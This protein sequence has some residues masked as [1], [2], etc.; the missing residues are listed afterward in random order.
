[1]TMTNAKRF[2]NFSLNDWLEYEYSNTNII[3]YQLK[4]NNHENKSIKIINNSKGKEEEVPFYGIHKA[5]ETEYIVNL[6][7][8]MSQMREIGYK[9]H[10]SLYES[11][12]AKLCHVRN[13]SKAV[14]SNYKEL[15]ICSLGGQ[16]FD[17]IL[18]ESFPKRR[19]PEYYFALFYAAVV[20]RQNELAEVLYERYI[21]HI[22]NI[23][24]NNSTTE[25]LILKNIICLFFVKTKMKDIDEILLINEKLIAK[26]ERLRVDSVAAI[27]WLNRSRLHKLD[28]N[29]DDAVEALERSH[30]LIQKKGMWKQNLYYCI[31][32][33]MLNHSK[34]EIIFNL[35]GNQLETTETQDCVLGWRISQIITDTSKYAH[36]RIKTPI[37][38]KECLQQADSLRDL[39]NKI[40]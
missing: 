27:L 11:I 14:D 33:G 36:M 9:R 24:Y 8:E 30:R 37:K 16:L 3:S 21:S 40:L 7:R 4:S 6:E 26:A 19:H 1:M 18:S 34:Q 10:I 31:Q 12:A 35:F 38:V 28:A 29:R 32:L 22:N 25:S 17:F 5:T 20:T 13:N 39:Y 2:E 23:Y 15:I